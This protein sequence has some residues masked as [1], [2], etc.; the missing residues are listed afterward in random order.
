M[1]TCPSCSA[2][3]PVA[4]KFCPQCGKRVHSHESTSYG[5]ET[6]NLRILYIM[7]GLLLLAVLFP[8]W[9]SPPETPPEFLGFHFILS[10][11][12]PGAVVSRMLQTIQ[13]VTIA[14]AGLYFSWVFRSKSKE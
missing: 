2:S 1:A 13:L 4:A 5:T 11:P 6:L 12:V 3:I 14:V 7:V 8:P 9:E 10:P